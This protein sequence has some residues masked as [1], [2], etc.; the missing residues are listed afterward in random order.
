MF[1]SIAVQM[2]KF[3]AFLFFVA[4]QKTPLFIKVMITTSLY[5]LKYDGNGNYWLR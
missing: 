1:K 4:L 2:K 3:D 5:T